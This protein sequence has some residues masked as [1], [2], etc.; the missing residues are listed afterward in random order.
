MNINELNNKIII[1]DNITK[2]SLLGTLNKSLINV[3][4]ITL[5]ELKRK[6]YFDYNK[7]T[8]HYICTKYN[9]IPDIAKMYIDNIYYVNNKSDNIKVKFLLDL[10]KEL[11]DNN[12]LTT[13]KLFVNF[14]HG[15]DIILYNLKYVDK[16]YENIF[17]ELEKSSNIIRI[18]ETKEQSIKHIYKANTIAE[19]VSFVASKICELIKK[20]ININNIKLAN[21]QEN[22][23]YY[24]KYIFKLFNLPLDLKETETAKGTKIVKMF[25]ENFSNDINKTL[26]KVK[27]LVKTEKDQDIYNS[28]IN[29]I[30]NYYFI[31]NYE[32]VKTLIFND[33]DNIKAKRKKLKNSI[34]TI[35]FNKDIISDEDYVFLI[36]FN[37][38]IIPTDY[39]DEDYL[40]D[41]TKSELGISTSVDKSD[42][43]LK[44]LH[45]KILAIKNLIVTYSK[46]DDTRE[47]Y[48]SSAYDSNILKEENITID[49][50][51]SNNFNKI[52]L[53]K[54]MDIYNKYG[55]ADDTLKLLK[56]K[57][58][59]FIYR[60][61]D[62][63]FKGIDKI[64]LFNNLKYGL[65]L[66]YTSVNSYYE[67]SFKYYLDYILK[68]NKYEDTFEIVIGNIFHKILSECFIDN[69]DFETN[70]NKE[71]ENT[72]YE[73]NNMEHFFLNKLKDEL[74]L[75][76]DTI[77]EQLT[78]TS[79]KKAMYEK[80][81]LIPIDTELNI[82]FKG[83]VDKI[84]YDEFDGNTI[85]AIIDY[86]TG[87]PNLNIN[88]V[89]YGLEMQLPVYIYLIN[90]MTEIKNVKIGGFYL[91][92]ILNNV[93]DKEERIDSLKLQGYSNG[94]TNILE[95]V[96]NTYENSE[97]IKSLRTTSN[98]FYSY[99][100]VL[101]DEEIN[102]LSNKTGEKI[103]EAAELIK[104]TKFDI[105]PKEIN[106][107]LV[108]CNFCKY[109]D[110]CY[111]KNE[112]IVKLK[113]SDN[114]F[115][116]GEE[117]E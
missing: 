39:K 32:D 65:T 91:Q 53:L 112:D 108:G 11:I 51:N 99:S 38:G 16:F 62:N 8:I 117:N 61:Y 46:H 31:D 95:K 66:S 76:I 71:I 24:L 30:N 103:K 44:L 43:E 89:E 26:L 111:K 47:I 37:E 84:L 49:Y 55:E 57:Y 21:V 40:N 92:K 104:Q 98:G 83:F 50:T 78:H 23:Y 96:D 88:N 1:L 33:I 107:K 72:K 34:K 5:D 19:E 106:D 85:V 10:K 20:G 113:E 75:I 28:I 115:K 45:E 12:L 109:K 114:L 6:Y 29:V 27:E 36:N 35:N 87:N 4:F 68:V 59:N 15:K 18:D 86:K 77:K 90:N 70:W 105:N 25:K 58:T 63:K 54:R 56:N 79:L 116:G 101:N 22:Y 17:K 7:E 69:Y 9:V 42:K 67:C 64:K 94:D 13:N 41:L 102:D 110:I 60:D 73:F 3:K 48:V 97:V 82:R 2:E 14:L 80:E 52:E 81:I 100:K 74:I 93:T